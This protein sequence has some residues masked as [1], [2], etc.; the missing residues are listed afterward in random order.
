MFGFMTRE[1]FLAAKNL[2]RVTT[3]YGLASVDVPYV[4]RTVLRDLEREKAV[5]VKRVSVDV[6]EV[7]VKR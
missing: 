5:A 3:D 4:K 6:Y 2:S 7:K 1:D